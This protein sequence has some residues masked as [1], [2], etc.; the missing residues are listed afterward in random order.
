[1][2]YQKTF[3]AIIATPINLEEVVAGE[4]LWGATRSTINASVVFL[5]VSLFGLTSPV[6][7]AGILPLAFLGGLLFASLGMISTAL[8][9]AIEHFNYPFFLF[10][11]PMFLFSGTFFPIEILPRALQTVS[12]T[13]FP[14]SHLVRVVRALM[15]H[16]LDLGLLWSL[17]WMAG[18]ALM[19][20]LLS[21]YLMQ[22]RLIK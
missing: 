13:L 14:L 6:L 11:T 17:L 16:R 21:L 18:V 15:L 8:V 22:R 4:I 12:F 10:V 3:D 1:M 19:A 7:L 9:P 2:Y 20:F 5:V